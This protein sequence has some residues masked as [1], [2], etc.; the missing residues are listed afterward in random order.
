VILSKGILSKDKDATHE[1]MRPWSGGHA[2]LKSDERVILNKALKSDERVILNK[3]STLNPDPSPPTPPH[4]APTLNPDPSP[5][6]PHPSTLR[7]TCSFSH[8][9]SSLR[10]LCC[11]WEHFMRMLVFSARAASRSCASLAPEAER[12]FLL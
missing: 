7:C 5:P 9:C 8:C 12:S 10:A 1:A 11:I 2:S 3:D 4:Y 6:T